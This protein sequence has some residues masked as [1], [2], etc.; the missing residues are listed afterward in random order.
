MGGCGDKHYFAGASRVASKVADKPAEPGEIFDANEHIQYFYHPDHLGSSS[1]VTD[2]LGQVFQHVQYY[3]FG[4]TWVEEHSSRQRAPFLFTGKELDEDT[5]LYYFGAR[6]YDP[7]T[8]VWLSPDPILAEY[9]GG[10]RSGDGVYTPAN[11]N[12]YGYVQNRPVVAHDPNGKETFVVVTV[13]SNQNWMV[14][15]V[16]GTGTH[17]GMIVLNKSAPINPNLSYQPPSSAIYDP[18]GSFVGTERGEDV[19]RYSAWLGSGRMLQSAP[20]DSY[21][22]VADNV[23]AY[24]DYQQEEGSSTWIFRMGTSFAEDRAFMSE[25]DKVGGGGS[26][27]C[28]TNCSSVLRSNPRFSGAIDQDW[29]PQELYENLDAMASDSASGV[30]KMTPQ[31]FLQWFRS[32]YGSQP[33]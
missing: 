29:L 9:L 33:E 16:Y 3:P 15:N 14:R 5:G 21:D 19:G 24:I 23:E 12:L 18:S 26:M 7:R 28:T 8:S 31:E 6:Y 10:K 2:A 13:N 22:I 1:Y 32:S 20:D 17:T 25:M 27:S 30:V 4:E 11:L